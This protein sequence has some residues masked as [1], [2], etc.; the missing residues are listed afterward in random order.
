MIRPFQG[1]A[2]G[3]IDIFGYVQP[4]NGW[5]IWLRQSLPGMVIAMPASGANGMKSLF[6]QTGIVVAAI[7]ISVCSA[8]AAWA[9]DTREDIPPS[10]APPR[11]P[12]RALPFVTIE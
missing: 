2:Y 1:S 6:T 12:G 11:Q 3:H 9:T 5:V 4:F 8:F 10:P 7:G